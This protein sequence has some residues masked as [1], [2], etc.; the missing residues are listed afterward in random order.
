MRDHLR[1]QHRAAPARQ[2]TFNG[3]A[4]PGPHV[5][6]AAI[7][8]R[9]AEVGCTVARVE[10]D[11]VLDL[12]SPQLQQVIAEGRKQTGLTVVEHRCLKATVEADEEHQAALGQLERDA[13]QVV[14]VMAPGEVVHLLAGVG[15]P[16]VAHDLAGLAQ[17]VMGEP[18][19]DRDLVP[20]DGKRLGQIDS[21]VHP[22][23][24]GRSGVGRRHLAPPCRREGHQ[25][26]KCL[27]AIGNELGGTAIPSQAPQVKHT[28]IE[29]V[30]RCHRRPA[31]DLITRLHRSVPVC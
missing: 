9:N 16:A 14:E 17:R 12:K 20:F 10:P 25:P 8:A 3:G 28:L 1:R 23:L 21:P 13:H 31:A 22:A 6:Q 2:L 30:Q 19:A 18:V 4:Q 27:Q 15:E 7:H 11:H 5:E 24:R 29:R 26:G